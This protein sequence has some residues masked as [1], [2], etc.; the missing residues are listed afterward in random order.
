MKAQKGALAYCSQ[1][2]LGLI[3]SDTKVDVEY[4]D[5]NTAV[6]W[7][8]IHLTDPDMGE[9][10]SSRNPLVV[11]RIDP[12]TSAIRVRSL[13]APRMLPE[14]DVMLRPLP[15]PENNEAS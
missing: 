15:P 8:G 11:G 10:W 13:G 5:G 9:Q 3:T 12:Q 14:N 1:N 4:P 6:A 7:I 2:R